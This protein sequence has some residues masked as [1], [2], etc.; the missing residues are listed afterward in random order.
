MQI[1]PKLLYH[2]ASELR[3]RLEEELAKE[4]KDNDLVF[5]IQAALQV[6]S[7][8][9]AKDEE[10]I[11]SL[12]SSG[13]ITFE[14]LWAIVPPNELV[15]TLD[16]LSE[17]CVYRAVDSGV[18]K[19]HDGTVVFYILGRMVDSDGKI[20]GW[21]RSKT[22]EIPI[23]AGEKTITDLPVYPLR[24]H[25]ASAQM[26]QKLIERGKRRIR[27]QKQGFYEYSGSAVQE[28]ETPLG[29]TRKERFS[30]SASFCADLTNPPT[31]C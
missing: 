23:F 14:T 26:R 22:L 31:T 16:S 30:V 25:K 13:R 24:F 27:L 21:T 6:I 18:W 20:L 3:L 7:E 4:Q 19:N 11:Q 5:E 1:E 17:P 8:D 10:N 29:L 15:Y 9:F 12:L 2:C 28:T